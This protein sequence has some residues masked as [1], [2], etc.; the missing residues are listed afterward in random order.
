MKKNTRQVNMRLNSDLVDILD[1]K[2]KEYRTDRTALIEEAIL[3]HYDIDQKDLR[4]Y[5]E[6]EEEEE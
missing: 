2:A 6:E 1:E 5:V 4:R 3:E